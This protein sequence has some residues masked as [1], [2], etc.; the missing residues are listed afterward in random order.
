MIKFYLYWRR[1][2]INTIVDN[3]DDEEESGFIGI[4]QKQQK[5]EM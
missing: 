3:D 1:T 4:E 2:I 5:K